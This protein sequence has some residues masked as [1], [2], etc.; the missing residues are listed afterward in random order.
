MIDGGIRALSY[1]LDINGSARVSDGL[2][3]NG[4]M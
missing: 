2:E 4:T 1:I 3:S